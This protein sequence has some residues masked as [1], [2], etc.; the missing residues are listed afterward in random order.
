[1]VLDAAVGTGTAG[2]AAG[3]DATIIFASLEAIK[4]KVNL[5]I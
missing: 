4:I 1:V 2:E 5:V 3:V